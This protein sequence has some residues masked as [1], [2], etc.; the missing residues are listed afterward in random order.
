MTCDEKKEWNGVWTQAGKNTNCVKTFVASGHEGCNTI[1]L[2]PF[3]KYM[4]VLGAVEFLIGLVICFYGIK[5]YDK[6]IFLFAFLGTAAV[7]F[8]IS[9]TFYT[10]SATPLIIGGIL[11]VICGLGVAYVFRAFI[12]EH[13]V[14]ILGLVCGGILGLMLSAPIANTIAKF[15]IMAALGGVGAFIGYKYNEFIKVLG[16]AIVGS[17]MIVHGLGQYIG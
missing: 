14:A 12:M 5:V 2:A 4:M 8:G 17:G 3:Y 6:L 1:N 13:G 7:V 16:M 10:T 15:A 11:A 9:F